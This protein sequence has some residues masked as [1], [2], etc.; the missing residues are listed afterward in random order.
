MPRAGMGDFLKALPPC[1][2]CQFVVVMPNYGVSTPAAFAAYDE[3]GSSVHPDCLAQENAIK[4]GDFA[5]ICTS[6]GNAL[7]E[8]SGARDTNEIKEALYAHG[9][10]LAMMTGSGAAVFG[11]FAPQDADKA[12]AAV[13]ALQGKYSAVYLAK[14]TRHGAKVCKR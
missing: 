1:P 7:E 6:A 9:A 12:A 2:A 3:V 14:P 11:A 10:S 8:C 5:G 13:A 4:A